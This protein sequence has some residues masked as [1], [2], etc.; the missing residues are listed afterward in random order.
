MV[1]IAFVVPVLAGLTRRRDGAWSPATLTWMVGGMFGLGILPQALQRPD[2]THLAWVAVVSWSLLVPVVAGRLPFARLT[3]PRRSL[4]ATLAVGL[5]MLVICP[6]YTYRHHLLHSR[7]SIGDLPPPFLVERD[8]RR[9]WF[10]DFFVAK[11][12]SEMIPALDARSEPGDRLIVGPADLSRTIYSDVSVYWMFPELIPATYYIEMDPGLADRAGSGLADDIAAADFLVLTNVW[13]GWHE[14]NASDE[15]LSDE[16]NQAVADHFCLVERFEDNL[17]LLFE[18]CDGG[19]GV[20][21][22]DIT[23][24]YPRPSE[25]EPFPDTE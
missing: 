2:S 5:L 11:A 7:V 9:F 6:F 15:H 8:G 22:A 13:T 18:R 21:P 17:V 19:G 23:G 10:G 1:I 12:L 24:T 14:P 25:D 4:A 16:G 3:M 20:S